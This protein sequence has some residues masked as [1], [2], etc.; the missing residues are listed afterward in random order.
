MYD[1]WKSNKRNSKNRS[2]GRNP[3]LTP[4]GL[5]LVQSAIHSAQ[6][7]NL[8]KDKSLTSMTGDFCRKLILVSVAKIGSTKTRKKGHARV[9]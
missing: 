2:P 3:A 9:I 6:K 7:I 4:H 8:S 5:S 1:F